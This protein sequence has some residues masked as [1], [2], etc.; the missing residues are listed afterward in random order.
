MAQPV[1]VG[2][3]G[4]LAAIVVD[5]GVAEVVDDGEVV[6]GAVVAVVDGVTGVSTPT[7]T[8]L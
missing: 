7:V 6:V 1:N 2:A 3:T 4:S 5:V 8:V